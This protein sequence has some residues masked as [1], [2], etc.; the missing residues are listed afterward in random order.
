MSIH[1]RLHLRPIEFV[2]ILGGHRVRVAVTGHAENL[3]RSG[4]A[5][6]GNKENFLFD[7]GVWNHLAS[8]RYEQ[9]QK[10]MDSIGC[11]GSVL[12]CR[13]IVVWG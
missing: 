4:E 1:H 7:C 8:A 5:K 2:G 9:R 11:G 12:F 6:K 3:S 13:I 10:I